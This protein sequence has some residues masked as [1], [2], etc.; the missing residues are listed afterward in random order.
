M[1]LDFSIIPELIILSIFL[2]IGY[3]I[4]YR[5]FIYSIV[6]PL[7]IFVFTTAFSSVLVMQ[8]LT[9]WVD[10]AHFF[11]CQISL[12]L[13]FL[14]SNKKKQVLLNNNCNTTFDFK[15]IR[16]LEYTTYILLFFY[17]LSNLI[18]AQ[19]K[20]FALLSENPSSAKVSYFQNGFGIFRKVNWGIGTF[21]STSLFFLYLKKNSIWFLYFLLVVILFTSL[22]G[23][24]SSLLRILFSI[25]AVF[26]HPAFKY[27]RSLLKKFKQYLPLSFAAVLSV[28]FTVLIKENDTIDN[29]LI[30]F[31]RRLL[32][33]ADSVLFFFNSANIEYFSKFSFFEYI[34]RLT[35]P[36]LGFFRIQP[37]QEALGNIMVENTLPPGVYPDVIVGPNTPFYIEGRIYF[38]FWGAILYSL[39][40]GYIYGYLRSYYFSI[41]SANAFVFVYLSSFVQLANAIII[42]INLAVTQT[43]DLTFFVIPV[44]VLISFL[45]TK[46]ITLHPLV[47]T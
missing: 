14:F 1:E 19:V 23:S 22:E 30:A 11:L 47:R 18:V 41:V 3:L 42:D 8:V 29:A 38:G 20:G 43:F 5:K 9:S 12:W 28:F 45:L 17:V 35:N 34:S 25:G 39:L 37:Y 10:I 32:Y 21:I 36:I 31:I 2:F 46:K 4:L 27:K 24:K 16:I 13:G 33:S 44:F 7:F 15:D 26:Y 6:D 40:V